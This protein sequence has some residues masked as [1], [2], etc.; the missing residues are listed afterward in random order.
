MNFCIYN[1]LTIHTVEEESESENATFLQKS[2]I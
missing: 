1:D 2:G